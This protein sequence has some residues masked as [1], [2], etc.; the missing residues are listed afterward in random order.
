MFVD[1]LRAVEDGEEAPASLEVSLIGGAVLNPEMVT[2]IKSVLGEHRIC[3]SQ[4]VWPTPFRTFTAKQK[5]LIRRKKSF[6]L[7]YQKSMEP[8]ESMDI[9][10]SDGVRLK[11]VV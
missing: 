9:F 2:R 8:A 5:Y 3:V 10:T 7:R 6:K 11:R 1:L 4:S